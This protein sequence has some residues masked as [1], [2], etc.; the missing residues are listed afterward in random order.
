MDLPSQ[1][2]REHAV[3]AVNYLVHV[4]RYEDGVR[5]VER[6]AEVVGIEGK[7]PQLQDI[8]VFK[9]TGRTENRITGLFQATGVVPRIVDELTSRGIHDVDRNWFGR[10]A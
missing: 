1:A 4:R 5:R 9:P 7:T 6:I 8:F 2:I 10:H 3:S